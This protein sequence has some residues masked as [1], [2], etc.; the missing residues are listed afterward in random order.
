MEA[1]E[2]VREPQTDE[3]T[4]LVHPVGVITIPL[5]PGEDRRA[6]NK[7]VDQIVDA[8]QAT[9]DRLALVEA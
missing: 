3:A 9:V 1:V 6:Y 8:V 5:D 7:R 2:V 4:I